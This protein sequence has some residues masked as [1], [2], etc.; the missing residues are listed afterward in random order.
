M[1]P[2]RYGFEGVGVKILFLS[3][4]IS[5]FDG[6]NALVRLID[7][8][9]TR[10]HDCTA[11]S[12]PGGQNVKEPGYLA[13]PLKKEAEEQDRHYIATKGAD[14]P[15]MHRP[16]GS[17]LIKKIDALKPDI[18]NIHWTHGPNFIPLDCL[19]ALSEIAPLFW[20]LHDMWSFTGNCFYSNECV[21]FKNEC[22]SC[23]RGL[24]DV[25]SAFPQQK[26][27]TLKAK[28]LWEAKKAIYKELKG[29]HFIAPSDWIKKM[30]SESSVFKGKEISVVPYGVPTEIFYPK[31]G[32]RLRDHFGL[33]RDAFVIL[34][35]S[36]S[37]KDPRKGTDLFIKAMK[38]IPEKDI[39]VIAL[40]QS[41]ESLYQQIPFPC[42]G[43]G[44]IKSYGEMADF[45]NAADLYV[46]PTR[47]DNLPSTILESL[48]C[49]LPVVSF[50]VGGVPE[51][52]V[53]GN[54]YLAHP[55]SES[56]LAE[57]IMAFKKKSDAERRSISER[58]RKMVMERF[59]IEKQAEAYERLFL[60][61]L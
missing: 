34:L 15:W 37:F 17:M 33:S 22:T 12:Y 16:S 58:N 6:S 24:S 36:V 41:P 43:P 48:S 23:E 38:L 56:D 19:P 3:S 57:G 9:K 32:I 4:F 5:R 1:H 2:R 54:G 52:V 45:Y 20:T 11:L 35:T 42:I 29:I 50:R 25:D 47:A 28:N 61:S 46:L 40:G 60:S 27:Y 51:M 7:G 59:T 14:L 30:A 44:L 8:M 13:V 31:P 49:G 10:K 26:R 53:N 18:I 55:E 39:A 21:R